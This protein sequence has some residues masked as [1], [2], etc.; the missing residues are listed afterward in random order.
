MRNFAAGF[1]FGFQSDRRVVLVVS[2]GDEKISIVIEFGAGAF[3]TKL[4]IREFIPRVA[5][6]VG[7]KRR[8]AG[9]DYLWL[10]ID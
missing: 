2:V 1:A 6:S 9:D 4:R 7:R 8:G 5:Q 10:A 3:V